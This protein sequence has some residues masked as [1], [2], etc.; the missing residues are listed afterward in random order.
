[1]PDA[2]PTRLRDGPPD[3]LKRRTAALT[4]NPVNNPLCRAWNAEMVI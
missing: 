2:H 3:L 1:M 4:G